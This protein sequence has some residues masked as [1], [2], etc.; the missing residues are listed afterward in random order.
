MTNTLHQ[1]RS[2]KPNAE[3]ICGECG[4][5]YKKP[6]ALKEHMASH[7]GERVHATDLLKLIVTAFE[8][9]IPYVCKY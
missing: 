3:H 7:S 5:V 8:S 9:S 2:P 4:K 6:Q 1:D